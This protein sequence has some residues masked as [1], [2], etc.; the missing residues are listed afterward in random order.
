MTE[1]ESFDKSNREFQERKAKD[2][3]SKFISGYSKFHLGIAKSKKKMAE[4][5]APTASHKKYLRRLKRE[6]NLTRVGEK[7][8]A[9]MSK[10][11]KT[12]FGL[13]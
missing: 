11:K 12:I 6:D 7:E 1:Q 10:G 8:L 2:P 3:E 5:M 4:K 13:K 9:R